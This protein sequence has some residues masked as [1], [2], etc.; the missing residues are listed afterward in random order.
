MPEGAGAGMNAESASLWQRA[1]LL[2]GTADELDRHVARLSNRLR[3]G[4]DA[5]PQSDAMPDRPRR[6][7]LAGSLEDTYDDLSGIRDRIA[8]LL[9]DVGERGEG[10]R[11][12]LATEAPRAYR[13]SGPMSSRR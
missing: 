3:Y 2:R 9:I 1:E 12:E 13:E 11:G 7:G 8:S 5:I 6:E 10:P 4:Q